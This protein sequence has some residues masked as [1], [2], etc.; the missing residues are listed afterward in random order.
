MKSAT[1]VIFVA[2]APALVIFPQA[3]TACTPTLEFMRN[4]PDL[5]KILAF[6]RVVFI[7]EVLTPS[8]KTVTVA[9][10]SGPIEFPIA[11]D[12]G[13]IIKFRVEHA[14]RGV[15]AGGTFET[16]QGGGGDCSTVFTKGERWLFGGVPI[17]A[18]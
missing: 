2:L 6:N 9:T 7:G 8:E 5:E 13:K 4:G 10:P 15:T 1:L 16:S 3:A 14:I 17:S 18:T 11:L 12:R